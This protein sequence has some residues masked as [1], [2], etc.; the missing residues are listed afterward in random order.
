MT[1]PL[2]GPMSASMIMGEM[3]ITNFINGSINI[4]SWRNLA[5]VPTGQISYF[6]FYGKT[7]FSFPNGDFESG[8]ITVSDDL[9]TMPTESGNAGEGDTYLLDSWTIY[10]RRVITGQTIIE[11]HPC[12]EDTTIPASSPGDYHAMDDGWTMTALFS[13]DIPPNTGTRSIKL[14]N[15]GNLNLLGYGIFRGPYLVNETPLLLEEGDRVRFWWK[16]LGGGDAFDVMGYLLDV[17]SGATIM[18]I[19]QTGTSDSATQPWTAVEHTITAAQANR[20]YKFIFVCGSYDFS[21]GRLLGSEMLVKNI[22]VFKYW[23]I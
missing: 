20:T 21:G 14:K 10:R 13:P 18:L 4:P 22:E 5:I 16:A 8:T 6:D 1:L 9:G 2:T 17:N 15:T 3:S 11:G 23:F 12:P 7:F 19:N